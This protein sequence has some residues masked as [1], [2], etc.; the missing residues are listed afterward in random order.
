MLIT[1]IF[2]L[3]GSVFLLYRRKKLSFF[4]ISVFN[5]LPSYKTIC[6]Q[7]LTV[8]KIITSVSDR[9][10]NTVGNG[11]NAGYQHFLLFSQC[12]QKPTFAES[13]KVR[14]R[15][16]LNFYQTIFVLKPFLGG[17]NPF[18]NII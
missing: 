10:V 5:C 7:K 2:S 14:M 8:A 4:D 9:S 6:R 18:E 16:W 12:F 11:E 3:T 1:S 15:R 13:K 17:M